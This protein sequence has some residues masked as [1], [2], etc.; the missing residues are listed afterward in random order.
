[1]GESVGLKKAPA[2]D[3][4]ACRRSS[5]VQSEREALHRRVALLTPA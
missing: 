2:E 4:G 5:S 1:M 3:D